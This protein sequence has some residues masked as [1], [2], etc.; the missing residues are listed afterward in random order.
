M[1]DF[2]LGF[3][4]R[5]Y[6]IPSLG[7]SLSLEGKWNMLIDTSYKFL[8]TTQCPG[9]GLVPNW[10]LVKESNAL[11]LAKHPG[12]F[13]GS[14]TPQYEFGAEASRT[15]WRIAVD[16]IM[17]P[18]ESM[19]QSRNFLS[20]LHSRMVQY[21][22][23]SPTDTI[24]YFGDGT[25]E[26]CS[27]IVNNVFGSWWWNGFIF[28]PVL[29]TLGTKIPN[30]SFQG[31]SFSQQT[32]IDVACEKVNT[33]SSG[34]SYYPRSWQVLSTMTLNG[35]VAKA[36]KIMKDNDDGPAPTTAPT[37]STTNPPTTAPVCKSWCKDNT[38]PWEKKCTW[39]KCA[40]C[41]PCRPSDTSSPT[42]APTPSPTTSP[43]PLPTSSLTP[44]ENHI[45]FK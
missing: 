25:L 44:V 1:R 32:M 19:L 4:G 9:T 35:D 15:M 12:S 28:G 43:T 23:P 8:Q 42:T 16:A 20:P 33:I 37:P 10:A 27:P 36:G 34:T 11:E 22:N 39:I 13:S 5:T 3:E 7:D 30:D 38:K 24:S 2:Q 45:V 29:S 21:F 17:Y 26:E 14:G 18:N 40:G 41:D 6:T 31:K